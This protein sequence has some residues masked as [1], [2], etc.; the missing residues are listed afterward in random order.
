MEF[1]VA[2]IGD[3]GTGHHGK[4]A[5][6]FLGHENENE[7]EMITFSLE[8]PVWQ[9]KE[10][11]TVRKGD[12]ITISKIRFHGLSLSGIP[13]KMAYYARFASQE[14]IKMYLEQRN[15]DEKYLILRKCG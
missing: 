1:I 3:I 8:K 6:V 15:K 11:E 5:T 10:N 4:F 13:F 7:V 2:M 14:E 12:W 9:E